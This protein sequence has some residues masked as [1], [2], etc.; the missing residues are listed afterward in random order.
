M[1]TKKINVFLFLL[2]LIPSKVLCQCFSSPGNPVGG[3]AS[4]GV[5]EKNTIRFAAYYKYF[6][7]KTHYSGNNKVDPSINSIKSGHYNYTSLMF[8]YGITNKLTTEI[9]AGYF[10]NK[11]YD[12]GIYGTQTGYGFSNLDIIMKYSPIQ[13]LSKGFEIDISAGGK[14]PLRKEAQI[15]ENTELPI[16]LQSG[17]GSFGMLAE[18]QIIKEF[19]FQ[20]TR[21]FF[22]SRYETYL[23]NNKNYMLSETIYD[24]GD[25]FINSLYV[26]KHL[27][28]PWEN[29]VQHWTI[30]AQIRNENKM[31]NYRNSKII[32]SSG[33][34]IILF[35]PQINYTIKNK[36]N[37]SGIFD[38]PIYRYYNG[39][40]LGISYSFSLAF[41]MHLTN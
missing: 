19:S 14:I 28:L 16:D 23:P 7:S 15:Y 34:N 39:T 9:N 2:L 5:L 11:T 29:E 1:F 33:N 12:Y 13:N 32:E 20:A 38:I 36:Y 21:I 8:G 24:F 6:D 37:I 40:Q 31:R 26:S 3:T 27:K 4:M 10:A 30:I 41:N 35:S 22:Y 18:I 25:M 17:T